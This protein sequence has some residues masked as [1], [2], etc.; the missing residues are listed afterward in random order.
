MQT[1]EAKMKRLALIFVTL[2]SMT[3]VL[4][5]MTQA[6]DENIS[7][8]IVC[9]NE[10]LEMIEVGDLP[11][12]IMGVL[13]QSGLYFAST[14]EIATTQFTSFINY[15]NGAGTLN[16][17]QVTTFQDGS[18][19]FINSAGTAKPALG[20]K[21]TIFEGTWEVIGGTARYEGVKGKGTFKGE[22]IG[23]LKTGADS[24]F[25]VTGT[26]TKK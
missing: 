18:K 4:V 10:K 13:K 7:G 16:V 9:H 22:R 25:D 20:G 21:K 5:P 12:H 15:T 3:G 6:A 14:G 23:D 11:G 2:L 24:Y 8:R 17:Q 26:M 1:K 19:W